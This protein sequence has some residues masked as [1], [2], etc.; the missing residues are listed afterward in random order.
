MQ[1]YTVEFVEILLASTRSFSE[2]ISSLSLDICIVMFWTHHLFSHWL[3][4]HGS[5]NLL[6]IR[7]CFCCYFVIL[8][9]LIECFFVEDI[10]LSWWIY[11]IKCFV[12]LFQFF[13]QTFCGRDV[14]AFYGMFVMYY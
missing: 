3:V 10:L 5:T 8:A 4:H 13:I 2:C 1:A 7:M 11:S 14:V 6:L 12:K 9:F